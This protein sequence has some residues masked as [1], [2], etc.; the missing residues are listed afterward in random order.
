MLYMVCIC[1]KRDSLAKEKYLHPYS[2]FEA[3]FFNSSTE[4]L[5]LRRSPALT[6]APLAR[7]AMFS[8]DEPM[9]LEPDVANGIIVLPEKS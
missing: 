6:F 5:A 4:A 7:A 1:L 9:P 8:P 3:Q 2:H